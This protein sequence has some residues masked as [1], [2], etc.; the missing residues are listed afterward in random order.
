MIVVHTCG[1]TS[2]RSSDP[3]VLDACGALVGSCI[4]GEISDIADGI[5]VTHA[6]GRT[7]GCFPRI[8][9]YVCTDG[10][11]VGIGSLV[12]YTHVIRTAGPGV[13]TGRKVTGEVAIAASP[14]VDGAAAAGGIELHSQSIFALVVSAA[15]LGGGGVALRGEARCVEHNLTLVGAH[16]ILIGIERAAEIAR[17][18]AHR[19]TAGA[20]SNG[21][22]SLDSTCAGIKNENLASQATAAQLRT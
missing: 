15:V 11:D 3:R 17:Q 12:T 13:A 7:T 5:N 10:D 8:G 2:T 4:A 22:R 18:A 16:I 20:W 9:S 1:Q 14:G 19:S 6:I 21:D